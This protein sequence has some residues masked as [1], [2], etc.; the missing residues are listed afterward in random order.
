MT[1]SES[2][3]STPFVRSSQRSETSESL[4]VLLDTLFR[5]PTP[6]P[7]EGPFVPRAGVSVS[8]DLYP[9]LVP[10]DFVREGRDPGTQ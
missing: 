9:G 4:S 7:L 3:P 6:P 1:S 10:V 8:E 5:P 2:T